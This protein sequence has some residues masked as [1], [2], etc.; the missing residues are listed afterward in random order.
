M[1]AVAPTTL[2]TDT[3]KPFIPCESFERDF[4]DSAPQRYVNT[5]ELPISAD[6]LFD[7]F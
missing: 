6:A 5:V 4:F 7:V 2:P 3:D 1:N